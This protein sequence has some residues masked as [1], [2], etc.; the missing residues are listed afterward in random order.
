ME[1]VNTGEHRRTQDGAISGE[2][3]AGWQVG[4]GVGLERSKNS[5]GVAFCS[6]KPSNQLDNVEQTRSH[7]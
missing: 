2:L 1:R 4:P 3:Q 5:L 7:W 6:D